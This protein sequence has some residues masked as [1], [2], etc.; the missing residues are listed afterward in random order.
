[1]AESEIGGSHLSVRSRRPPRTIDRS[2]VM[3]WIRPRVDTEVHQEP[4]HRSSAEPS[5][6]HTHQE[7]DGGH[8]DHRERGQPERILDG[9][10]PTCVLGVTSGRFRTLSPITGTTA[11]FPYACMFGRRGGPCLT[12]L[13]LVVAANQGGGDRRRA[14]SFE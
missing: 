10:Q 8:A 6:E 12:R 13:A 4:G 1:M 7:H 3:E 9:P 2:T 5:L 11:G 14:G